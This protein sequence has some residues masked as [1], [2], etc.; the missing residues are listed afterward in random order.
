M[1]KQFILAVA[2]LLAAFPVAGFAQDNDYQ[3]HFSRGEALYI[4]GK[5]IEA[6][7]ELVTAR[8]YAG[9]ISQLEL[10]DIDFYI[11]MSAYRGGKSNAET[12]LR[13]YAEQYPDN[14]DYLNMVRVSLANYYFDRERFDEAKDA[15]FAVDTE[16]LQSD[17][18]DE[19]NFKIGYI[20]FIEEN[21]RETYRYMNK[22]GFRSKYYD[23]AL[24]CMAY[25]DYRNGNF[26]VAQKHF[27]SL[28]NSDAYSNVVPFYMIQIEFGKQ[29][30]HYVTENVGRI[31][32][33]ADGT[34]RVELMR[35]AGEAWFLIGD[36][37]TA[38]EYLK[39]YEK[40]NG[41]MGRNENYMMGFAFY[42]MEDYNTAEQYLGK[43]PGPD[44]KLSQNASYHLGDTYIK[45]GNKTKAMQ[46]FSIASTT[47]Y[48]DNISEDAMFNYGKLQ[49]ELG[50]GYFNEAIN[51]LNKYLKLYPSSMR[52]PQVKE[53]LVAAYYNSKN[54]E[55]AYQAISQM[56][57]PDNNVKAAF[58]RITYFRALEHY[59]AG[60]Y[61]QAADLLGKSLQNRYSIKYTAL[62]GFWQGEI[63]FNEGRYQE[64]ARKY[65]AYIKLS[66]KNERE[67]ML[68][69]YNIGYTYF[70]RKNWDV[71][72]TWFNDFLATY[73][74]KDSYRAD[75]YNRLGDIEFN[76][77]SYWRAIEQY[78]NAAKLN[79]QDKYYSAFQRAMVLGMVDRVTRKIESLSAIVKSAEGPYVADAMY[80]LGRTY[81]LQGRYHN[82]ADVLEDY[83]NIYP[84]SP[85]N[86]YIMTELGL[87]YQNLNDG[88]R[89]LS[90][91]Q[92]VLEQEKYSDLGKNAME[93][94]KGIYVDR[95]RVGEYFDY[96]KGLGIETDREL[97][98]R[99][100]LAFIA[101]QKIYLSGNRE[102][103]TEAMEDYVANY[104]NGAYVSNALYYAGENSLRN[105]E[106]EAAL[107]SF[108]KLTAM[109]NNSYTVRGLERVSALA[110][111]LKD[112][113]AAA[114]AYYALSGLV[115][116]QQK[117][118]ALSGY[119]KATIVQAD[120]SKISFAADNIMS[121]TTD[122]TIVREAKFAKAQAQ[123]QTGYEVSAMD[124]YAELSNDVSNP[125]GAASAYRIIEATYQ[126]GDLKKTEELIFAFTDKN[127]PYEYWLG[128]AFLL[129]GDIYAAAGD[130]FQARA[131]YQSIVDGYSVQD[132]GVVDAANEKI[133]ELK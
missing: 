96:I 21:Y 72:R 58:Q 99:D 46:S 103:A 25:S 29:N 50:G 85:R 22:V 15:F 18:R 100:S 28:E 89:A 124:I 93:G 91:Y 66:P 119:L 107:K 51:V 101:A 76:N 81:M 108:G 123:E 43:V 11:A 127:T 109:Y 126:S 55:A 106:K 120:P 78:D 31:L 23:H 70:N 57:N 36:W 48:D 52:V 16:K 102:I 9:E 32:R 3:W 80:E 45:L 33:L 39:Q 56:R 117:N 49:Y 90:Y 65:D 68:A 42:M 34:R 71:A 41:A 24:Y 86:L 7:E 104:P 54:Y 63:M 14:A 110:E 113:P 132:D 114:D 17:E 111:E 60:D 79:T 130:S 2:V 35:M 10:R 121:R 92:A 95:N 59:N 128:K 116:G 67:N 133:K 129:L 47:G 8:G 1:R 53:Y 112:Y 74:K 83:L 30:Y 26:D 69:R 12:L 5:Y 87:I 75:A 82:A 61:K 13:E 115:T 62:A 37:A 40:D 97:V 77:K 19:V 105:G 27:A 6:H 38:V 20:Y 98:Q 118:E 73:D 131:T 84:S 44:D 122:R 125:E 88:D 4:S 94:I 64:A